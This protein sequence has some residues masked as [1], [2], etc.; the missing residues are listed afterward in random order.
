[1]LMLIICTQLERH[2]HPSV[3]ITIR[4]RPLSACG[5]VDLSMM[6]K[7]GDTRFNGR[8]GSILCSPVS[9]CQNLRVH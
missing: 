7:L 4:T 1:M 2:P 9:L 6:S 8:P 3:I 5:Q